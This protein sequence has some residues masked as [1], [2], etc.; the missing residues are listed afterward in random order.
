MGRLKGHLLELPE[1]VEKKAKIVLSFF[2][3]STT[4]GAKSLQHVH[5]SLTLDSSYIRAI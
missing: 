5:Q 2:Y 4:R 1:T 3:V